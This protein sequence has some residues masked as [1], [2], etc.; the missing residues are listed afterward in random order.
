MQRISSVLFK[1]ILAGAALIVTDSR[2]QAQEVNKT[3][4][5]CAINENSTDKLFVNA[6]KLFLKASTPEGYELSSREVIEMYSWLIR[7][8]DQ[9]DKL[10]KEKQE[11]YVHENISGLKRSY[12]NVSDESIK[13]LAGEVNRFRTA[14][15]QPDK[16]QVPP[17]MKVKYGELISKLTSSRITRFAEAANL[18]TD[19]THNLLQILMGN[20]KQSAADYV[21]TLS[22]KYEEN[23]RAR[24]LGEKLIEY[25]LK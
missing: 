3:S 6:V 13:A 15:N 18:K 23:S 14:R 12:K 7:V 22:E 11:T 2:V 25:I 17:G 1:G 10:E 19:E 20:N 24:Q 4:T 21:K 16:T 5:V 8:S 9:A